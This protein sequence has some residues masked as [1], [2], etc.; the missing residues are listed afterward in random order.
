MKKGFHA[1][2]QLC[3]LLILSLVLTGCYINIGSCAMLAKHERQVALSE[4]LPAGSLFCAQTHNGSITIKGADVAVCDLIAT[5]TA[6]AATEE[7]AKELAERTQVRLE[8]LGNKLT[9]IIE[10]PSPLI[11]KSVSVSLNATLPKSTN[12]T[13]ATHNGS[14]ELAAIAGEIDAT[15]HNGDVV[16]GE[17]SGTI[18]MGTHNGSIHCTEISGNTNLNTHNGDIDV[19]YSQTAPGVCDISLVSHNGGIELAAP[20]NLSA[21]VQL[22]THNGSIKTHLPI[23][24]AGELSKRNIQGAIGAGEGKLH[25]ETYNGSITLR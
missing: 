23:K 7:S 11:N 5:I 17:V 19:R 2:V 4:P 3:S 22:S 9:V 20:P 16:A 21:S 24:V 10:T 12:L 14:V 8:H 15:S 13:L 25:L 6:R 18:K 1:K